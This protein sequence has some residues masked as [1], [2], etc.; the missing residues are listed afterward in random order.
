[1]VNLSKVDIC[2][3]GAN[4]GELLLPWI[5]LVNEG[6]KIGHM[7]SVIVPY[8]TRSEIS[9]RVAAEYYTPMLFSKK[10]RWLVRLLALFE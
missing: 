2:I 10:I 3:L 1:M 9:K 8:P 6:K 7:A 5:I 4:A